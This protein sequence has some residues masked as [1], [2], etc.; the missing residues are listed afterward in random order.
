VAELETLA[1][2]YGLI[3]APRCDDEGNLYFSDVPNGG[4]Y[5][6]SPDGAVE[7]VIPK[8]RYV[9]GIAL[10]ADGGLVVSGRTLAH[11]KDGETRIVFAPESLMVNDIF[12]DARGRVV[13]GRVHPEHYTDESVALGQC[14]L[15]DAEGEAVELYD[16][17]RLTNGL[18]FSPDGSVLYQADTE[19]H[20]V[21]AHD[22]AEDGSVS[23]RRFLVQRDDLRPDG[24]AVDEEGT[25]W[26]ADTSGTSALR[27]FSP[28]GDEVGRVVVPATKVVSVCFGGPDR[29]DLYLTTDDNLDDPERQGTIFRTRADVPGCRVPQAVV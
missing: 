5:R 26:V 8:R 27:G 22:F 10:H 3:E 20:G 17:V 21:L 12:T 1:W 15:V 13:C 18:G 16:G 29:R 11:V 24:L 23:G 28:D 19:A 4:V 14:W 9:G 2:G 25:V 6:L 7:T